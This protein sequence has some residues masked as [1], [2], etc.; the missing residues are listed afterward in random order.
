MKLRAIYCG[1]CNHDCEVR[2]KCPVCGCPF[3]SWEVYHNP[4][5]VNGTKEYC[6]VCKTELDGLK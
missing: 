6:P 3:G 5:N 4:E 1:F 2:Y